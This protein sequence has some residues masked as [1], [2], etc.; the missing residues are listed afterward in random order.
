MKPLLVL[1]LLLLSVLAAGCI[2]PAIQKGS[3]EEYELP[4]INNTTIFYLNVSSMQI[5]ENVVNTTSTRL[6][7]GEDGEMD[8]RNV[9]AVDYSGNNVSF[10]VSK[11]VVLGRSYVRFDFNTPFS[12]Y[13]AYTQ[14]G[15]QDFSR[16]LTK[17]GSVR[18]V[19]PA[20]FTTG[21]RFLGITQ[22]E[23]DN[24]TFDS[25]GKEVL[26]W[27]NPYPEHKNIYV[28]YYHKSAPMMLF[29]FFILF[30]IA[31]ILIW[32]YY[33][34]SLSALRKKHEWLEK[35]IRK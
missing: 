4:G 31:A 27:E 8:F 18:V 20:N 5:I 1:I 6:V 2:S 23:P 32:G 21:N 22:P 19:L 11:E 3:R 33:Y 17:N 7:I 12:G 15:S 14:S 28:K 25:E 10:N 35:G 24:I 26:I 34:L 30:S 9:V 16:M 29:Y 13:V